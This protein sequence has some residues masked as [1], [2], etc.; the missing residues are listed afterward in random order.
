MNWIPVRIRASVTLTETAS[1]SIAISLRESYQLG[2]E[3]LRFR[4]FVSPKA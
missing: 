1:P 3:V 4:S 2:L